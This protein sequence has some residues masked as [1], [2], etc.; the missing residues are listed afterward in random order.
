MKKIRTW[1]KS[2]NRR[3]LIIILLIVVSFVT[4]LAVAIWQRTSVERNYQG[5]VTAVLDIENDGGLYYQNVEVF[6]PELDKT[7]YTKI[8]IKDI[9][10]EQ[11]N[12][13]DVIYLS[14]S[15]SYIGEIYNFTGYRRS[16][17]LT[18]IFI[19]FL[20]LMVTMLGMSGAKY[21]L[22]SILMFIFIASG[23]LTFYLNIGNVY[24]LSF[25]LIAVLAFSSIYL[26]V[27]DFRLSAIVAIS[28]IVTMVIILMLNLML[29]RIT[30]LTELY[31]LDLAYI[32]EQATIT[33]FWLIINSA[34]LFI[35]FGASINTTLDVA[36][37]VM[38]KK[39]RFPKTTAISLIREGVEENKLAT[40]RVINSLFFVL[41]GIVLVYMLLAERSQGIYFV[42][43]P[44]VVQAAIYFM[45]AA[46]AAILV[47]PITAVVSA[48]SLTATEKDSK[49]LAA[50]LD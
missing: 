15:D 37:S 16:F 2:L 32:A 34:V 50:K 43:E 45:S 6:I 46:V 49:Q 38:E 1:L 27:R 18:W 48:I 11:V 20:V 24:L 22:P 42:D 7:T 25:L 14:Q 8:Q 44:H 3:Q 31:Y 10:L 30:F 39:A 35:A 12:S 13:G 5:R 23:A 36:R 40:A 41:S 21:V 28:Q 33:E 17:N 26:L 9:A 29:F 4:V 19:I 47:G